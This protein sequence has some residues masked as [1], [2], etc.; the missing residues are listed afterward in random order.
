M[1]TFFKH[2]L[3]KST[4]HRN[5]LPG[6]LLVDEQAGSWQEFALHA[7]NILPVVDSTGFHRV[8]CL[9]LGSQQASHAHRCQIIGK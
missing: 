2:Y 3:T 4:F 8:Q 5:Q 1:L 7:A 6:K 9:V